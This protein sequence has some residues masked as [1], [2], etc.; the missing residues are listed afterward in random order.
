VVVSGFTAG[1]HN[2]DPLRKHRHF[3]PRAVGG[4]KTGTIGFAC[5]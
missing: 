5:H 3:D 2:L 4:T 1:D